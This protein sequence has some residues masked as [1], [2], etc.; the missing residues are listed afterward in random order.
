MYAYVWEYRVSAEMR[1]AFEAAYGPDGEWVQLFRRG[2]GYVG[3]ELLRDRADATRYLTIGHWESAEL[4][5]SFRRQFSG[6]CAALA[7]R[8]EAMTSLERSRGNFDVV[9]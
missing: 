3:T 1:A 7:A 9:T 8:F 5:A 2:R 4:F 6:E